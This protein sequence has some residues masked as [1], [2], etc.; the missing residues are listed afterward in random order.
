M[1][2]VYLKTIVLTIV[3]LALIILVRSK[4]VKSQIASIFTLVLWLGL[5]AWHVYVTVRFYRASNDC[6]QVSNYLWAAHLFLLIEAFVNFLL[7]SC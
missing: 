5:L 4:V 7:L 1:I 3:Y 6:R 2:A